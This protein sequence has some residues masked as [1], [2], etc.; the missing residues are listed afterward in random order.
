MS[1][2]GGCGKVGTAYSS[3]EQYLHMIF[4]TRSLGLF[5]VKLDNELRKDPGV[6]RGF[7]KA[8]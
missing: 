5:R 3:L 8:L 2:R 6:G 7:R 4:G 1:T